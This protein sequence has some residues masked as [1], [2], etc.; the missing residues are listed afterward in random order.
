[1]LAQRSLR[2]LAPLRARAAVQRSMATSKEIDLLK[3]LLAEA[4][5]R[6]AEA[7]KAEAAAAAGG[8]AAGGGPKFQIQTFN[9]ISPVGLQRFPAGQF[10]LTGSSGEVPAGAN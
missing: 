3:Q 1:M 4:Q 2:R 6:E 9:A 10:A 8:E 5:N 7:A